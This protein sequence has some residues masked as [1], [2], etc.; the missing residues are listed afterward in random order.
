M[1]LRRPVYLDAETLMALADYHEL[2]LPPLT[3][4]VER[5]VEKRSASAN[6]SGGYFLR[7]GN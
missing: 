5:A 4:V 3:E 2:V 1:A 6:V 7:V